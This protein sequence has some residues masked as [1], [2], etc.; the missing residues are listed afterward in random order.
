M[1]V[2]IFLTG[3]LCGV[4]SGAVYDVFYLAR[5]LVCGVDKCAYTVKDK[6]FT[7]F[8]DLAYFA[9]FTFMFLFTS[10][11]FDFYELRAYMLAAAAFGAV[12]YLKSLHSALAFAVKKVYNKLN[13]SKERGKTDEKSV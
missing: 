7:A 6:I 4:A 12:I 10:V 9:A 5:V 1:Q 3:A 13:R 2:F 8:C 11:L